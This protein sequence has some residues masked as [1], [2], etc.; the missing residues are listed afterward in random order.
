MSKGQIILESSV[1]LKQEIIP[2]HGDYSLTDKHIFSHHFSEYFDNGEKIVSIINKNKYLA[3]QIFTT[4]QVNLFFDI[5][6]NR[7]ID[8]IE[9][10]ALGSPICIDGVFQANKAI[11][12]KAESLDVYR[13]MQSGNAI[14]LDVAGAITFEKLFKTNF[15]SVTA[16]R[17]E[18]SGHLQIGKLANFSVK[19]YI[20][21][22]V[23]KSEVEGAWCFSGERCQLG[24]QFEVQ[25]K[26]YIKTHQLILGEEQ[27]QSSI[28]AR[29]NIYLNINYLETYGN[30]ICKVDQ[31]ISTDHSNFIVNSH[32]SLNKDSSV[33]I[34]NAKI[35]LD[36]LDNIGNFQ[37]ENCEIGIRRCYQK[38]K[39]DFKNSI[40]IFQDFIQ[41]DNAS[42]L[43]SE[44]KDSKKLIVKYMDV[45]SGQIILKK[46]NSFGAQWNI[47]QGAMVIADSD[48]GIEQNLYLYDPTKTQLFK[49][50]IQVNQILMLNGVITCNGS[51]IRCQSIDAQGSSQK[52]LIQDSHIYAQ[53]DI[54]FWKNL[55]IDHTK[56]ISYRFSMKGELQADWV[57]L[58]ITADATWQMNSKSSAKKI[59]LF[60]NQINFYSPE[61]SLGE[62]G[63]FSESF[64]KAQVINH[65]GTTLFLDSE[66]YGSGGDRN[67]HSIQGNM[68]LRN[69]KFYTDS[70]T[71][72]Y[73]ESKTK[74]EEKSFFQSGLIAN[75]GKIDTKKSTIASKILLQDKAEL[76]SKG[77]LI[78][79]E[80][81]I[82]NRNSKM[83]ISDKSD[84]IAK[85]ILDSSSDIDLTESNLSLKESMIFDRDSK[86]VSS[87]SCITGSGICFAGSVQ[88]SKTKLKGHDLVVFNQFSVTDGSLIE[89]EE[90][91]QVAWESIFTLE[92]SA[93]S[94]E[95][96]TL[97]GNSTVD[98]SQIKANTFEAQLL[99]ETKL[100]GGTIIS[101]NNIII[102]DHLET[103]SKEIKVKNGNKEEPKKIIP[104]LVAEGQLQIDQS[105]QVSGDNLNTES[106]RME[107][108][109]EIKLSDKLISKGGSLINEGHIEAKNRVFLGFDDY[110]RN[111]RYLSA[112]EVIIHSNLLNIFGTIRA[113]ENFTNSGFFSVN[114]GIYQ[115]PT[116]VVNSIFSLNAGLILPDFSKGLSSLFNPRNLLTA[117][118]IALSSAFP[119]YANLIN[120][121][122]AAPN[123]WGMS[124]NLHE[125]Y[126]EY[127]AGELTWN[128]VSKLRRHEFMP[129]ICQIKSSTMYL[130]NACKLNR[131]PVA[132]FD[133]ID[134]G[135]QIVSSLGGSYIDESIAHLNMGFSATHNMMK[136]S[137]L[138]F[139]S[140]AELAL[141]STMVNTQYL[142]NSGLS[143][144]DQTVFLADQ[145]L[146][147]G[148]VN[149]TSQ[150]SITADTL[151]NRGNLDGNNNNFNIGSFYQEGIVHFKGG[152]L[153]IERWHD[154]QNSSSQ[155]SNLKVQGDS[156]ITAGNLNAEEV[157]FDLV[158][159][160]VSESSA[161]LGL[162]DV[163][164]KTSYLEH[165]GKINYQGQLK[166]ETDC[167]QSELGSKIQG[168]ISE[169]SEEV[170]QGKENDFFVSPNHQFVLESDET[171]LGGDM[172]GGDA[173]QI[174]TN[175][176]KVIQGA[177]ID[178][179]RGFIKSSDTELEGGLKL[180]AS[181]LESEKT[182]IKEE[183]ELSLNRSVVQGNTLDIVGE[184]NADK[185]Y[186][187]V[188]QNIAS[189]KNATLELQDIEASTS[190]FN[191]AGKMDY[192]GQ[193][194]IKTDCFQSEF[195]S[196]IHGQA[197][198]YS[199][200]IIQRK[201]NDVSI[202]PNHQFVLES[203]ETVL[204]GVM[205]GGDAT[206]INTNQ[207]KVTQG[208]D[209]N[210]SRGFIKSSD[211]E[212]EGS[213]KL[214]ASH[215]DSARTR[216]KEHG[217]L[218]LSQSVAQ[219]DILD[220]LGKLNTDRSH[221]DISKSIVSGKNAE[222]E[223]KNTG[224]KTSQL[225]H[226]GKM[227]YQG[228]CVIESEIFKTQQGSV[229]QGNISRSNEIITQGME[230]DTLNQP[231][232]HQFILQSKQTILGGNFSGG[233]YTQMITDRLKV[234]REG[235]INI[236][237]GLVKSSET[238]IEGSLAFT[239]QSLLDSERT[240]VNENGQFSLDQSGLTGKDF[241]S[242]GNTFYKQAQ[243]KEENINFL[244]T[245]R[246]SVI[247]SN[248]EAKNFD[249]SSRLDYQEICSIET[250][251]YSHRGNIQVDPSN[252]S[253]KSVFN[254]E[255]GTAD[256]S[257][258]AQIT[259][260][261]INVEKFGDVS[262]LAAGSGRYSNYHFEKSLDVST[263]AS[264]NLNDKIQR[265]CDVT[266]RGKS[267]NLNTAYD[268]QHT[269]G[270]CSTEGDVNISAPVNGQSLWVDSS[271]NIRT[272]QSIQ[273]G[274]SINFQ[275]KG[276]FYNERAKL[277]SE[278]V[279]IKT[280]GNI[281]N[282]GGE[283]RARDY[284]QLVSDEDILNN[285]SKH[286][287]KGK[288]DTIVEYDPGLIEGGTGKSTEGLG[289]FVQAKG[290][291]KSEASHFQSHGDIYIEG[292]QGVEMK[293][294]HHTY[295]CKD[296]THKKWYGK[297]T[298]EVQTHTDVYQSLVHSD[299]GRSTIRSDSGSVN[300]VATVF[301]SK[302]GTDIYSQGTVHL[303]SL[304]TRDKTS[305]SKEQLWGLTKSSHKETIQSAIPTLFAD[306]GKTRVH[307][308]SGDVDARG[309][310]F[311]G[312]GD[313]EIKAGKK[314]LFGQDVLNHKT[315]DKSQSVS[316]SVFGVDPVEAFKSKQTAGE[317]LSTVD[318]TLSKVNQLA[319]SETALE[320]GVNTSNLSLNVYNTAHQVMSGIANENLSNELLSRSGLGGPGGFNPTISL[321]FKQSK[322]THQFQ[323]LGSGGVIRNN[324]T[325]E[326]GE[327]IQLENGVQV[328]ANHDMQIKS[329]EIMA[330]A[331]ELR[332]KYRQE[333]RGAKV[334]MTVTG[335][336]TD[337]GVNYSKQKQ[338]IRSHVNS[339]I[340]AGGHL[341][342]GEVEKMV[343]KG[344]NIEAGSISGHI[345]K[346]EVETLQDVTR[347]SAKQF[348]A[349]TSGQGSIHVGSESS[350]IV[351]QVSGIHVK[352][353]IN[354][355][356]K[357]TFTVD[358]YHS[359][360]GVITSD[361]QNNFKAQEVISESVHDRHK[362]SGIGFSGN[363]HDLEGM[364]NSKTLETS[365][366]NSNQHSV[367]I[368]TISLEH[369]NFKA[370]QHSVIH[371]KQGTQVEIESLKGKICTDE[372]SG[373]K[374]K[375]DVSTH[376]NMDIPL[377]QAC[378]KEVYLKEPDHQ[379]IKST[380]DD[381]QEIS[382]QISLDA[383]SQPIEISLSDMH[384][385]SIEQEQAFNQVIEK[386][387]EE[388]T[389]IQKLS[390]ETEKELG[391]VLSTTLKSVKIGGEYGFDKLSSVF[392][393]EHRAVK[394][395]IGAKG[396]MFSFAMNTA[397][398]SSKSTST[399]ELL[400]EGVTDTVSDCIV[401]SVLNRVGA[402]PVG[403][404]MT[405]VDL[406]DT[407]LYDEN[408]VNHLNDKAKSHI[409][410]AYNTQDFQ[411]Q[412]AYLEMADNQLEIVGTMEALHKTNQ[413][414]N[415][416]GNTIKE[417]IK[418]IATLDET[419][420]F[421]P[422][423]QKLS[424]NRQEF[425]NSIKR[426]G[427]QSPPTDSI[428]SNPQSFVNELSHSSESSSSSNTLMPTSTSTLH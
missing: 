63:Y 253:D 395:Y 236:S 183:G 206:Q 90:A 266:V 24:G 411:L 423:P 296:K 360:G 109:G 349:S 208:S 17:F 336:V 185:T 190:A 329:P 219:G 267:V 156:L 146:N 403:W 133:W 121:A 295:V 213:L 303:Q 389:T 74:L 96:V 201:E 32:F 192:Q 19:N 61:A 129:K 247:N 390:P 372:V 114:L 280:G 52:S 104:Q 2:D 34:F 112:N 73:A 14:E 367:P 49:S 410:N 231:P 79:I 227:N 33:N 81:A 164:V 124:H 40:I 111:E 145:I 117:G 254:L 222:L 131:N 301:S 207:F 9:I 128:S 132:N 388:F 274:Q 284:A 1:F 313:L 397:L 341:D 354:H 69:S 159:N 353:G 356:E 103:Q 113:R 327:G 304:K 363:L 217:D 244:S 149:G 323:T 240:Q 115:S 273:T 270:L 162:K 110:V 221:L 339:G 55:Q 380:N 259:H 161:V 65:K 119:G 91:M 248:F 391:S 141:Q 373:Y 408:V 16:G 424:Q 382:T 314:I 202:T 30:T 39:L 82:Y 135:K 25:E 257:G 50:T 315:I 66:I 123:L 23:A 72:H 407:L 142:F 415:I 302:E 67:S 293:A 271:A 370:T 105:A 289:L 44:G 260:G 276:G 191:H 57:D 203:E 229:V 150:L 338:E 312:N 345:K 310:L 355:D 167:F 26:F 393:N 316:V 54:L 151:V 45:N 317:I 153:K 306:N 396:L 404:V 374:I 86:L 130:Y 419:P 178:I 400:T 294:R 261:M 171:V 331:A 300:S 268:A 136:T 311:I 269:L 35:S 47:R 199:E 101:G 325:L 84:V 165:A 78:K 422:Q 275:A 20:Q 334:G 377:P 343:L 292:I 187:E 177:D 56:I 366:E 326:A 152:L 337:V 140:G 352:E 237:N 77:S 277:N 272:N 216:V 392:K 279:F 64:F 241:V 122:F 414:L 88:L 239:N 348:S 364:I 346:L 186:F 10:N 106:Q 398:S 386:A 230:N 394:C 51:H 181:R 399:K 417:G 31:N 95:K 125:L 18:N 234:D 211:T 143:H 406:A 85:S 163:T 378:H 76:E 195:G 357:N 68:Q 170:V 157:Y 11:K 387:A 58:N 126:K 318:P 138:H 22:P 402:G 158:N 324:V 172:S 89:I 148:F 93:L 200:T 361:G 425:F 188:S 13:D 344:A 233:D 75:N 205:S 83:S 189:R 359:K 21:K 94:S 179:S 369:K 38:N 6:A 242:Q 184:L 342:L 42:T 319:K 340:S 209:I 371:G 8:F 182:L 381:E 332:S 379:E 220:V 226:S 265:D 401:G 137:F 80:N 350:R 335:Q 238:E 263:Q 99:S 232:E 62:L 368:S 214:T 250:E 180:T 3:I 322:T 249:D 144:G 376:F 147:S 375:K 176:F 175:Q 98:D 154:K 108:K 255:S 330:T 235:D 245:A 362:K 46:V 212:L 409:E 385:D 210:I 428:S 118:R 41:N 297:K 166:V 308:E 194:K 97:S 102:R 365:S 53:K 127:K 215:L 37:A 223:L 264:I 100:Y 174:N 290:K 204:G 278:Q 243:I 320:A 139:N 87:K 155:L 197:S 358:Q 251:K 426:E 71:F 198:D 224:V 116:T 7:N 43:I 70:Q 405:G 347:S 218:G 225:D 291:V 60:A 196:E 427:T 48:V 281:E 169:L 228:Q 384:F 305:K 416:P 160:V 36:S 298:H 307:S 258:S 12:I 282:R 120:L 246:E 59:Q 285:S 309:A 421:K 383:K 4:K 299:N 412:Q 107:V 28:V 420:V 351:N 328:H 173:T 283:I 15:L 413:M 333:N 418:K 252:E 193:I 134:T 287:Y 92:K 256:L 321:G 288:Y 168:Q 5:F 286:S 29:G 262:Q 27:F